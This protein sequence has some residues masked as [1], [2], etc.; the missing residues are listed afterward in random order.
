V[1][2]AEIAKRNHAERMAQLSRLAPRRQE[3]RAKAELLYDAQKEVKEARASLDLMASL[4]HVPNF[5]PTP[6]KLVQR[7]IELADL[8][9]GLR[10]LEPSAGKGDIAAAVWAWGASQAALGADMVEV[11]CVERLHKLAEHMRARYKWETRCEDFLEMQPEPTFDRVLMNP[12]FE[13]GVDAEHIQHAHKF[14]KPRGRLV[15]IACATTGRKLE[16]WLASVGGRSEPLPP[17]TFQQ[18]ERPTSVNTCLIVI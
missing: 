9:P 14:L 4:K 16:D 12:P 8:A 2:L 7:M 18:S 6:R 5:F 17:G 13:R 1:S 3:A 15:A 11:L 10:V